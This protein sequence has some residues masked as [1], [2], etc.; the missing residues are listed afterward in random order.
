LEELAT[1]TE[2]AL[3]FLGR[4]PRIDPART[5]VMGLSQGGWIAPVVAVNRGRTRADT[6]L[7]FKVE[8]DVGR[9]LEALSATQPA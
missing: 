4:D 2:A 6:V 5:G 7:A 8:T 1:D 3:D 9:A